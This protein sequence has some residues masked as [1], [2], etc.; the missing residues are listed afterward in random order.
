MQ[1]IRVKHIR[2]FPNIHVFIKQKTNTE[3]TTVV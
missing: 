3:K 2:K 1:I